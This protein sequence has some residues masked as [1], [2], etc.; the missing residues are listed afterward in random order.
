MLHNLGHGLQGPG[1][2]AEDKGRY[3]DNHA[4]PGRIDRITAEAGDQGTGCVQGEGKGQG[5][6]KKHPEAAGQGQLEDIEGKVINRQD[7]QDE[8][9]D[10][11]NGLAEKT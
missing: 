5:K 6:Q 1:V 3:G 8:K 9:G 2:A 4:E 7:R 10:L 11:D